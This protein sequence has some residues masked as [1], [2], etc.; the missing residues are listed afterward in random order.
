[1]SNLED[2]LK[3]IG[4]FGRYQI[5]LFCL[6][7]LPSIGN[8]CYM[9]AIVLLAYTPKHRCKIPGYDNDT[10]AIQ[11][12]YHANL[13][14][15]TIPTSEDSFYDYDRCHVYT[16]TGTGNS[17]SVT[18]AQCSQWVYDRDTFDQTIVTQGNL[19]CSDEMK[20][21][22]AQMVY[23]CGVL[24]GDLFFGMLSDSFGRRKSI[25][26]ASILLFISSVATA[27]T[28]EFYS[29]T[30]L[31]FLVGASN[32]G[33]FILVVVMGIELT[34][35][36]RRMLAGVLMHLVFPVGLLYL[37]GAGF[38]LRNWKTIQ[39][40][41]AIPCI[42][43]LGLYWV[44]P[45]SPRWLISQGRYKDAETILRKVAEKNRKPYPEKIDLS[46]IEQVKPGRVWQLFSSK[47]LAWRTCIIFLNWFSV[48]QIFF[49]TTIHMSNLG[50]NFYL[51]FL[52]LAVVEI[53][54]IALTIGLLS[55]FGRRNVLAFFMILSGGSNL[56]TIFT[57][58]LGGET[59]EPYTIALC[60]VGKAGSTGAFAVIYIFSS[61]LFPTV[62]RTGGM[63]ASSCVA[64]LGGMSAPYI[65]KLGSLVGSHYGQALPLV[66]FGVIS[67]AAGL[68]TL[69]LPETLHKRLPDTIDE[70]TRFGTSAED[71][72]VYLQAS[73]CL[74]DSEE[75][76]ASLLDEK[77]PL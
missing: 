17:S 20:P 16:P 15:R 58:L 1:M 18:K 7:C 66:I 14:N 68:F 56:M 75:K 30:V 34:G 54:A 6:L 32:H 45:E 39:L 64:R 57:V 59:F 25:L 43:H 55:K 72:N 28:T 13:I 31:E 76:R 33:L 4:E 65:A 52:L 46:H 42:V 9:M 38:I 74:D 10:W 63:G 69:L 53:P 23:Y 77:T 44:I 37:T 35:P 29:F 3:R 41:V 2:I 11:G 67:V 36:N 50:G 73:D 27:F 60:C 12:S 5:F 62:V 26:L 47:T 49:G 21:A 8:G 70:G 22:H 24:V 51:K 40:V 48:S 19:V 61:E 71:V